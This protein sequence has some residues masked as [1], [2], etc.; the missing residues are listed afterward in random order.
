MALSTREKILHYSLPHGAITVRQT[1]NCQ[2]TIYQKPMFLILKVLETI[3]PT[4]LPGTQ[5]GD[6]QHNNNIQHYVN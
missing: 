1:S 5:H 4:A 3:A 2:M 6:T